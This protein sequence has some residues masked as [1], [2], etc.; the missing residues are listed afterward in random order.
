MEVFEHA[1]SNRVRLDKY[2]FHVSKAEQRVRI[3]RIFT[4]TQAFIGKVNK[5][6]NPFHDTGLFLHPQDFLVFSGNIKRDQ[7]YEMG[8]VYRGKN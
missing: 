7:W 4:F 2:L 3:F 5:C 1:T 6:F 8:Y